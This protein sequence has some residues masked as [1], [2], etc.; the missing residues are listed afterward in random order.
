MQSVTTQAV[1]KL[2]QITRVDQQRYFDV[3]AG[4]RSDAMKTVTNEDG[5]TREV[6][7]TPAE[8]IEEITAWLDSAPLPAGI[9]WEWTGDQEDEAE[10]GAFLKNASPAPL[11]ARHLLAFLMNYS[12]MRMAKKFPNQ[13]VMVCRLKIGCARAAQ[14]HYRYSCMASQSAPKDCILM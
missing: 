10:S 7:M 5:A 1:A 12:L 14:N 4:V 9:E 8:R 11:A 6:K 13:K 3:K 2:G